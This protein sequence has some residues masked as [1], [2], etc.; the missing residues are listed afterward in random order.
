VI[1]NYLSDKALFI[2]TI[3]LGFNAEL[4]NVIFENKLPFKQIYYLR[5]TSR[6]NK[7]QECSKND[8]L[9]AK[10][11]YPFICANALAIC[12]TEELRGKYGY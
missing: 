10:F 7:W 12:S 8:V 5:R 2:I 11:G 9:D 4:D 6:N 1:K 3:P